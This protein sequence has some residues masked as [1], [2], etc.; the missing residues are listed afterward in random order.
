MHRW[1]RDILWKESMILNRKNID[2]RRRFNLRLKGGETKNELDFYKLS[3]HLWMTK[4]GFT[5]LKDLVDMYE[6]YSMTSGEKDNR[7]II[8]KWI[9]QHVW[10]YYAMLENADIEFHKIHAPYKRIT[11]E[12]DGKIVRCLEMETF[13]SSM[14]ASLNKA[15]RKDAWTWIKSQL[16]ILHDKGFCHG[17]IIYEERVN[18]GNV[19]LH[20]DA[21]R[22][23]DFGIAIKEYVENTTLEEQIQ[24]CM[25]KEKKFKEAFNAHTIGLGEGKEGKIEIDRD[26]KGDAKFGDVR[27]KISF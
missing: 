26:E 14:L 12:N 22:F 7:K 1:K 17:D 20:K 23:I 25:E 15:K 4:Q 19:L 16:D 5:H 24:L 9:P 6:A 10:D 3:I 8:V 11:I 13:G 2:E 21:F 27:K 18:W